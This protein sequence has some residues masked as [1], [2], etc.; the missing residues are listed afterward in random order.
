MKQSTVQRNT[1]QEATTQAI[2]RF[3]ESIGLQPETPPYQHFRDNAIYAIITALGVKPAGIGELLS[4]DNG[5]PIAIPEPPPTAA[6]QEFVAL[7][8]PDEGQPHDTL[9]PKSR[10]HYGDVEKAIYWNALKAGVDIE[11]KATPESA[12]IAAQSIIEKYLQETGVKPHTAAWK[13]FTNNAIYPITTVLQVNPNLLH[14]LLVHGRGVEPPAYPTPEMTNE[15]NEHFDPAISD[16]HHLL[17]SGTSYADV[18]AAVSWYA[19]EA[20]ARAAM[21]NLG[22]AITPSNTARQP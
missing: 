19:T 9:L 16:T 12:S 11:I 21:K 20:G 4:D 14:T 2:E 8:N 7:F 3:L 22:I 13:Y 1:V 10:L 6:V 17:P 18:I 15:F 5:N